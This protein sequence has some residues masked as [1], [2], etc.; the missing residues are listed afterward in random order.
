MK[1]RASFFLIVIGI[2]AL[3]LF[4]RSVKE[5]FKSPPCSAGEYTV[6]SKNN[7]QYTPSYCAACPTGTTPPQ[8]CNGTSILNCPTNNA[9]CPSTG[10]T[11]KAGYLKTGTACTC[12][13]GYGASCTACPANATCDGGL[14]FTCPSQYTKFATACT[15]TTGYGASCTACPT[16]ATCIGSGYTFTC[17]AGYLKTGTAC[18]DCP[19]NAIC[20]GEDTFTCK[21]GYLKTGTACVACPS[22]SYSAAGASQCITCPANTV[23]CTSDTSFTCAANYYDNAGVCT[24][25]PINATCSTTGFT[26]QAG[27]SNTGT[28]CTEC[29]SGYA[30]PGSGST[31]TKCTNNT[32]SAGSA[33]TCTSCGAGFYSLAGASQCTACAPNTVSCSSDTSFT[34]AANYFS[35]AGACTVCPSNSTCAPGGTATQTGLTGIV[36]NS[37]YSLTDNG[38]G[39]VKNQ[40]SSN[41]PNY[42]Q[43]TMQQMNDSMPYT[44]TIGCDR[45][46]TCQYNWSNVGSNII[47]PASS[48]PC[49]AKNSWYDWGQ[50][51]CVDSLGKSVDIMNPC[52]SNTVYNLKT[53]ECLQVRVPFTKQPPNTIGMPSLTTPGDFSN[54]KT[55][56]NGD[57]TP[58]FK[59]SNGTFITNN[60]CTPPSQYN[61]LTQ[62]CTMTSN[63]RTALT[64]CGL[65]ASNLTTPACSNL[66]SVQSVSTKNTAMCSNT[67]PNICCGATMANN[68]TCINNGYWIKATKVAY[69]PSYNTLCGVAGFDDYTNNLD[70][71]AA[72]V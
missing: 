62:S 57:C 36:C 39:C 17:K 11:C 50:Q 58:Y 38:S 5:G 47:G 9:S 67:K 22:G 8:W 69:N 63:T 66:V 20:T 65:A 72:V 7:P 26:C 27:Y 28:A 41:L 34:C 42:T 1:H 33:A 32:Y 56:D 23:S 30:C 44:N 10:F 49:P 45:S 54:C 4:R 21:A 13:T 35:N 46:N 2:V 52:G 48:N 40:F 59:N 53:N 12:T 29:P 64:C 14:N 43:G 16:N 6:P 31:N 24:A 15:C 71:M 61:F 3:L 25:C 51:R 19:T 68:A 55:T 70:T 18:V 37:S 60:P